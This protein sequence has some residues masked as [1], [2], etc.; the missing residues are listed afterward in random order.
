MGSGKAVGYLK[1][2][3]WEF[4]TQNL[5]KLPFSVVTVP[6]Q[7][8]VEQIGKFT[9]VCQMTC[10]K[11]ILKAKI[12]FWNPMIAFALYM[13]NMELFFTIGS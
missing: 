12:L 7:G 6:I 8:L 5:C 1:L 3:S 11:G 2:F 13:Q 9:M 4:K 10:L